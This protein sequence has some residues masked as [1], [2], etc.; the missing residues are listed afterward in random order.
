[1]TFTER[2]TGGV[3]R[4]IGVARGATGTLR[5]R[6]ADVRERP[7]R[8][9]ALVE[10][11]G[12]PRTQRIVARYTAPPRIRPGRPRSMRIRR[13]RIRLRVTWRRPAGAVRYRVVVRN[14]RNGTTRMI[15]TRRTR[16]VIAG[17]EFGDR[18][19]VRVRGLRPDGSAGP[20]ARR[21]QTLSRSRV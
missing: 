7:R 4:V 15:L 20:S 8:I 11:D 12:M 16:I 5:F 10:Q 18:V 13:S 2:T 6:A 14:T 17:V 9:V 21:V 3:V 19:D 1:M